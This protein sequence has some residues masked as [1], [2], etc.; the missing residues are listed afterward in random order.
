MK[1]IILGNNMADIVE[2]KAKDYDKHF[3]QR[4]KQGYRIFP[5]GLT[6]IRIWDD[7]VELDSDEVIVYPENGKIPHIT[8]GLDYSDKAIKGDIDLHRDAFENKG[9]INRFKLFIDAGASYYNLLAPFM[10]MIIAGIILAW[11]LLTQG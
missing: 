11:A 4:R 5:D 3:L 6:R 10:G 8:R 2:I 7:G 9:F 1:V